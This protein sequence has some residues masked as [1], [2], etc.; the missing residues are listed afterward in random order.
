[1]LAVSQLLIHGINETDQH[2]LP[3]V[4]LHQLN[5]PAC[6]KP[7]HGQGW[8]VVDGQ[9]PA[10]SWLEDVAVNLHLVKQQAAQLNRLIIQIPDT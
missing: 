7:V 9:G 5:G 3:G 10:I 4:R 1:M 8:Y 2:S 6:L